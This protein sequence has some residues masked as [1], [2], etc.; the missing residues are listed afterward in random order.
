MKA[1]ERIATNEE[2][3]R[4]ARNIMN[5]E[6]ILLA[7][8]GFIA[9]AVGE[10]VFSYDVYA[11]I[12]HRSVLFHDNTFVVLLIIVIVIIWAAFAGHFLGMSLRSPLLKLRE[13]QLIFQ[14]NKQDILIEDET[15]EKEK[16]RNLII[17]LMLTFCVLLMVF[18]FSYIRVDALRTI[19]PDQN[20]GF[21][22]L[23]LPSLLVALE[24][25]SGIYLSYFFFSLSLGYSLIRDRRIYRN[26]KLNCHKHTERAVD[27]ASK[28]K[29]ESPNSLESNEFK[30]TR[31]RFKYKSI[32]DNDYLSPIDVKTFENAKENG[33]HP[34]SKSKKN[35]GNIKYS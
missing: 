19:Y 15:I 23:I 7:I 29:I 18:C 11:Y 32:R 22:D 13:A 3:K 20:Y 34:D 2:L 25:I 30:E 33:H 9:F 5:N 28:A 31:L 17:G 35:K 21:I 10:G 6:P 24:I 8:F 14:G 27:L 4:L 1:K 16:R 26:A 12:T